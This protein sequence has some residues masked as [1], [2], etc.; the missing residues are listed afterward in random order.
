[1]ICWNPHLSLKNLSQELMIYKIRADWEDE[2]GEVL[3][4]D[5]WESALLRVN[6]SSTCAKLNILQFKILHHIHYSKARLAKIYPNIDAS[7]DRCQNTPADLTHMFW[8]CPA[9]ATYWSTIFK[10]LSEALNIDLQP[11]AAKAIFGTLDRRQTTLRK[12]IKIKRII[13]IYKYE[14]CDPS[15]C[16]SM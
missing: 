7:C 16:V 4:E 6:N 2:L 10:M 1:M 3:E 14:H 13:K 8:S 5:I 9:L 15:V 11:N 12:S